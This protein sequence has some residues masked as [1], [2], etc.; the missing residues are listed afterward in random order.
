MTTSGKDYRQREQ[1]QVF[2]NDF[3][4]L[5]EEEINEYEEAGPG[6]DQK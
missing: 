6:W 1:L 2:Q 4:S 3:P 5:T